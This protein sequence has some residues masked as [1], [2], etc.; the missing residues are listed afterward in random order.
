[1]TTAGILDE[2]RRKATFDVRA[3]S[4]ILQGGPEAHAQR[5]RI[6]RI[7]STD[8][9]LQKERN[10]Y[11]PRTDR[12]VASLAKSA[13][14]RELQRVHGWSYDEHLAARRMVGEVMPDGVVEEQQQWYG[15]RGGNNQR[16]RSKMS[17]PLWR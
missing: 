7:I 1:M 3:L 11:L 15:P 2:E 6:L 14:L 16:T 4:V 8:E 13:R 17:P 9:G 12:H 5:Q 10:A